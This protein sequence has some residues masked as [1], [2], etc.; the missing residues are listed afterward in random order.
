[1]R[2]G[3]VADDVEVHANI[4]SEQA[5]PVNGNNVPNDEVE[6]RGVGPTSNEADLSRPSAISLAHRKCDPVIVQTDCQI[7][8]AVTKTE[9][10][11]TRV[12]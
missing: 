6:R 10:A 5:G 7:F 8:R 12:R 1:V 4:V 9:S 11:F 3:Y 2:R